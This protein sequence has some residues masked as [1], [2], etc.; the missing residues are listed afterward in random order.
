[1]NINEIIN[2]IVNSV[3]RNWPI[4]YQVRYA[5]IELGK[6]LQKDTDF[7]FSVDSKL[8][9]YNLTFEEIE[10]IYNEDVVLSAQVICKS[11]SKLLKMILDRLGI[12]CKLVKSIN[13]VITYSE[14][15][16]AIDINHW[17]LA[18]KDG[19]GKWFLCTLSSDLPYIQ[20]GMETKHFG[21]NISYLKKLSNGEIL[22]VY[23]GEKIDNKVVSREELKKIDIAINYV[24]DEYL[25]D[26]QARATKEWKLSY[27]NAALYMLRDVARND[28][29][30]Y[31]LELSS[32]PFVR[33]AIDFIGGDGRKISLYDEDLNTLSDEDWLMWIKNICRNVLNK[34]SEIVGYPLNP[35]PPIESKDW[36][37]EAWLFSLSVMLEDEVYSRLDLKSNATIDDSLYIDVTSFNYNKW[38]KKVKSTFI[39]DKNYDYQNIIL[40]LDKLNALVK[41]VVRKNKKIN[42]YALFQSL[43]THFIAPKSLYINNIDETGRLCNDYIAH[44]F[45]LMFSR[46][47]SC[48]EIKTDFNNMSYSEQIVIIK[49]ILGILFPEVTYENSHMVS[50]YDNR[51]SPILNRI[52]VFP[53]RNNETGDYALIFGILGEEINEE[54]KED[55][56]Y[57]FYDLKNNIFKI[58]DLLDVYRNYTIVSTRMKNRFSV[59]E[60]ENMDSCRKIK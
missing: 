24:T 3:N 23:E 59:E 58:C 34:L 38:S 56:Y 40:I 28:K 9:K 33:D 30:Y 50:D 31:E 26:E 46:V 49:E 54:E 7:F 48:N 19:D 10:S 11:A 42:L 14:D 4:M 44:K 32:T 41:A 22:Q 57:F 35:I 53:V 16:K 55:D 29:L 36:N 21:T 20:M 39:Y 6:Y 1:M 5:Y 25:Y 17:F 27:N 15:D 12:E 47:F 45:F 18:V 8:Q 52:Q 37:Y 51:Y 60:L 43:G 13:N 2:R